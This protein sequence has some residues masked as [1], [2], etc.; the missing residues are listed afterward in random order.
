VFCPG[1]G[2]LRV[3]AVEPVK[4]NELSKADAMA[5]GFAT[6][7]EMK[8]VLLSLYPRKNDGKSWWRVKFRMNSEV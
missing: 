1:L 7:R 5:D 4:W 8:K 3:E 6:L 2:Y